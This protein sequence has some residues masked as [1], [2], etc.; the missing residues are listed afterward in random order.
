MQIIAGLYRPASR[1]HVIVNGSLAILYSL[2]SWG[3]T[4]NKIVETHVKLIQYKNYRYYLTLPSDATA[5]EEPWSPW[6]FQPVLLCSVLS[7]SIFSPLAAVNP[8]LHLP[9]IFSWDF[10]FLQVSPWSLSLLAYPN[11][12]FPRDPATSTVLF[13]LLLPDTGSHIDFS[14]RHVFVFAIPH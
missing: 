12:S 9:T 14:V 7:A 2:E 10:S 11:S 3:F 4:C 13:W 1:L 6:W 8:F 5:L